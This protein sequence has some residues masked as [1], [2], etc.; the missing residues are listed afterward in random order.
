MDDL[1]RLRGA[2]ASYAKEMKDIWK[3]TTL[4]SHWKALG[5]KGV[6]CSI[7]LCFA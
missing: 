1:V 2:E 3:T 6:H 4:L 7:S 5:K